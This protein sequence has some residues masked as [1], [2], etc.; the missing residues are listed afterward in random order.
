MEG[1]AEIPPLETKNAEVCV[2]NPFLNEQIDD[3]LYHFGLT[4]SGTNF[5]EMFGDVKVRILGIKI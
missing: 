5:P 1:E 3:V 2:H 4:K